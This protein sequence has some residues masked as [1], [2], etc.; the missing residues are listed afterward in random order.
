[1]V[2]RWLCAKFAGLAF[3]EFDQ[4]LDVVVL[5]VI[6]L[7]QD[8]GCWDGVGPVGESVKLAG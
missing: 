5:R 8:G 6:G 7:K 1:M 2:G 3:A 4:A